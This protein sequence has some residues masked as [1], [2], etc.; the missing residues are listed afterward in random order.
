[1]NPLR[2]YSRQQI[3]EWCWIITGSHNQYPIINLMLHMQD[4]QGAAVV[5]H[6]PR[7][8]HIKDDAGA[9]M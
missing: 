8:F 7:V 9:G 4:G 2:H 6:H 5:G 3:D 1:L